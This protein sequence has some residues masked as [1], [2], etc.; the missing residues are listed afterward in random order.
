MSNERKKGEEVSINGDA[1]FPIRK[2]VFSKTGI[3]YFERYKQP[4][5]ELILES[6]PPFFRRA[7]RV[8]GSSTFELFFKSSDMN[9][10]LKV[11]ISR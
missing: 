4:V 7:D 10:V 2:V 1:L 3:G 9:D 6:L 11:W 5:F 8:K